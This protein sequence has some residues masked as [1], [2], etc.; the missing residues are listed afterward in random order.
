VVRVLAIEIIPC[1]HLPKSLQSDNGPAFKV[2]V[3][4][5]LSRV[6]GIN[7]HLHCAWRPQS[8]GKLRQQTQSLLH[9]YLLTQ[10]QNLLPS[11]ENLWMD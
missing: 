4:Q 11:R 2:E 3:T 6:L 5:G 8:S 7:Y 9:P 1:S 10:S